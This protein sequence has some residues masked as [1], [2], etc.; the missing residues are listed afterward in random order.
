MQALEEAD[1]L[2]SVISPSDFD[3]AHIEWVRA[4]IHFEQK[5]FD[6]AMKTANEAIEIFK[7]YHEEWRVALVTILRGSILH[8]SGKVGEACTTWLP[9]LDTF[10]RLDDKGSIAIVYA[11][12]AEAETRRDHLAD[13]ET[14]A[15]RAAMYFDALN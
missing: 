6:A 10:R 4:S 3:R 13:A 1:Q 11:N 2:L 5:H 14:Y 7:E 9:L 12:L 15:K 8:D